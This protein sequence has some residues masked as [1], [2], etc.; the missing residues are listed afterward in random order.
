M[1]SFEEAVGRTDLLRRRETGDARA[2]A[3][4]LAPLLDSPVGR[5]TGEPMPVAGG[6][7]LGERLAADAE[8]ALDGPA[9]VE[10][11]YE[12]STWDRAVGA[13]LGGQIGRRFGAES[14]PGRIRARFTGLGGP[15]LRR[16]PL[17]GRRARP[18]RRGE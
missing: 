18:G 10:P 13:R 7:E 11:V 8:P 6:G 5:Y 12:I 4:D 14:P 2:D 9:L 15:E 16:V 17:C 3:L 1:R